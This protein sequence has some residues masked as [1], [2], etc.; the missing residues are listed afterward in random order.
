MRR[1]KWAIPLL[2]VVFLQFAYADGI[3]TF[4]VSVFSYG[5]G[6]NQGGD[7]AGYFFAGPGISLGGGGSASC[8]WWCSSGGVLS[9][10]TLLVPDIFVDF[11]SSEGGVTIGGH[12]YHGPV[13]AGLFVSSIT[14]R[15]FTFPAGGN[16][17]SIF[18]V[19][20]PASFAAVHGEVADGTLFDVNVPPGELVLT[21]D[22]YPFVNVNSVSGYYFS[23]GSYKAQ[24]VPGIP[25][26]GTIGLV[27][28]GLG[29]IVGLIRRKRGW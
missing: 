8:V 28:T 24:G 14:A 26:P 3:N 23:Q 1:L 16:V 25:E 13:D 10:G 18:T 4:Q 15:G 20:L 12:T 5:F 27:A 19:T 11:E 29:G 22:Y 21:F 17:P 9:P 2:F 6:V 7:N